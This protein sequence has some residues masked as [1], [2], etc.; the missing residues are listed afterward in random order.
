MPGK[1]IA[2]KGLR[3][4]SQEETKRGPRKRAPISIELRG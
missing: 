2:S 3:Q 1:T 4:S